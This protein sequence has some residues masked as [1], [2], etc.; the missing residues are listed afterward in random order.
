MNSARGMGLLSPPARLP[1]FKMPLLHVGHAG[2][3][4]QGESTEPPDP[5][6]AAT[7]RELAVCHI[8]VSHRIEIRASPLTRPMRPPVG[9]FFIR[10]A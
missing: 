7:T 9:I 1:K 5:N 10:T 3:C 4:L 2:V 6:H 8:V